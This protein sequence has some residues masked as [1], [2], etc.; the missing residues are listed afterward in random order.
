VEREEEREQESLKI[1]E[2]SKMKRR[3]EEKNEREKKE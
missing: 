1:V 3:N 2:D